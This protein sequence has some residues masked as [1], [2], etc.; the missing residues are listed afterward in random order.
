MVSNKDVIGVSEKE[1]RKSHLLDFDLTSTEGQNKVLLLLWYADLSH[2][3]VETIVSF[4]KHSECNKKALSMSEM[5]DKM[6][7]KWGIKYVPK[8][9]SDFLEYL[10]ELKKRKI[11]I[12]D[13][14]AKK[15]GP[16]KPLLLN[17]AFLHEIFNRSVD[18]E[19]LGELLGRTIENWPKYKS[20]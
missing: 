19:D 20:V 5:F 9:R 13:E 15:K 4:L 1:L 14:T 2:K 7:R 6:K 3:D 17:T 11:F 12:A 10:N 16:V 18:L 8:H